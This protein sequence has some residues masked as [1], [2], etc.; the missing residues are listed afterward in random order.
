MTPGALEQ[1]EIQSVVD[2]RA[3]APC[4]VRLALLCNEWKC[5]PAFAMPAVCDITYLSDE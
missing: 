3:S 1:I 5:K 2:Y 4:G